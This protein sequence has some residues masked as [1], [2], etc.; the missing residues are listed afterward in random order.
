MQ[1]RTFGKTGLKISLL[2]YGTG[3]PGGFGRSVGL[4]H[5]D[6]HRLA[7]RCLELGINL[8]DTA[9]GYGNGASEA[10]LGRA[11]VGVPRDSYYIA[12]KWQHHD[13]KAESLKEDPAELE[14]SVNDSL[15]RLRT[16]H[17][18]VMQFHGLA[19]HHYAEA[20]ARFYPTMSKLQEQGKIRYIGFS[21]FLRTDVEHSAIVYA[22]N[23]EPELWDSVMLKYGILYQ[24]AAKS[25]LPL[26]AKNNV[27]VLNMAPVRLSLTNPDQL[28]AL[29]VEWEE[30]GLISA[31]VLPAKDPLGWLVGTGTPSVVAAGYKFGADHPGISTVI[32][33]TSSIE[34]LE[35]NAAA[36][37]NPVLSEP[38]HHRLVEI[39]AK[40]AL[41]FSP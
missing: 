19:P 11:L 35:Q 26:A 20:V 28:R 34:H 2:S 25:A 5:A 8:F 22:L 24:W 17:I 39:F 38:D 13:G 40:S 15:S 31:G 36:L 14:R 30:A 33:G 1:Y 6:Q 21:E 7:R 27:A 37:Q 10:D 32:T 23:T 12:T 18:D 9:E 4:T 16:D 41:P 29:L 3:G